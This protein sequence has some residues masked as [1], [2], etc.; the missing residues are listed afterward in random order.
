VRDNGSGI[1]QDIVRNR[2]KA[3]SGLSGMQ[4]RSQNISAQLS[5][6]SNPDAGTEI[7]LKVPAKIAYSRR[8]KRSPWN[9]LKHGANGVR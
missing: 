9:R 3:H 8:S 6:W 2:R 7:D 1:D 5:I 4:E